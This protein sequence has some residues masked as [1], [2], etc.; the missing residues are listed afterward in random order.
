MSLTSRSVQIRVGVHYCSL[1]YTDVKAFEGGTGE[2]KLP[3]VP[4]SEFSG[5]VLEV[6]SADSSEFRVGDR[7][8]ALKGICISRHVPCRIRIS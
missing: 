4:G 1:N 6:G 3:V 2:V 7:V 5:E 8:V